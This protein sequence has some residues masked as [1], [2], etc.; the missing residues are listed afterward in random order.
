MSPARL[1][2]AA[3]LAMLIVAGGSAATSTAAVFETTSTECKGSGI[4]TLC[5]EKEGKLFEAKGKQS[6]SGKLVSGTKLIFTEAA[7]G[8]E[9]VCTEDISEGTVSQESPGVVAVVAFGVL[10]LKGCLLTAPSTLAVKCVVPAENVTKELEGVTIDE[11]PISAGIAKP[12]SGT[13]IITV[14]FENKAGQTCPATVK[15][16]RN[17]TGEDLCVSADSETDLEVHKGE[18]KKEGSKLRFFEEPAAL[19]CQ[20]EVS[21]VGLG[22][23]WDVTLA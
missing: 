13:V 6:Y 22:K 2:L 3:G 10:R 21:L 9:I 14:S 23:K 15:G 19:E 20:S 1:A 5:I 7:L 16:L 4:P 18:C 17:V 11:M 12:V 8:L